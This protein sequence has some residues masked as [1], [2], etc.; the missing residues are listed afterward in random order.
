MRK[1]Y[2]TGGGA[3][4]TKLEKLKF[5]L[6]KNIKNLKKKRMAPINKAK[7]DLN[8]DGKLSGYEKKR[9]TAIAKAMK[10]KK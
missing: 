6:D 3:S 9:G 7:S 4:Q 1:K 2:N 10:G 5:S 8:K